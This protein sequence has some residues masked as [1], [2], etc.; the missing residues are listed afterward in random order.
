MQ[1]KDDKLLES[2]SKI[3][4]AIPKADVCLHY[5]IKWN[6]NGGEDKAMHQLESFLKDL[7]SLKGEKSVLLLSGGG[8]KKRLDTVKVKDESNK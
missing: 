2:A 8:K 4:E 5:S 1:T 6:Y 3:W 7:D